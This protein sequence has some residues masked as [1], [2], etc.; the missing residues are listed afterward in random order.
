MAVEPTVR[1]RPDNA[2]GAPDRNV[3]CRE[4]DQEIGM[5]TMARTRS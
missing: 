1:L 5:A 3:G 2:D 4:P